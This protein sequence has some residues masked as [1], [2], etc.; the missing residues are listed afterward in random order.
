MCRVK[1]ASVMFIQYKQK[2]LNKYDIRNSNPSICAK[3]V[4]IQIFVLVDF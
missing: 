4:E 2:C 3:L 1:A